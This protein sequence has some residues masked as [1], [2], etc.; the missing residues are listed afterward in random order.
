MKLL[1]FCP[2]YPPHIGGLESHADEFNK[3]L[4]QKEVDIT[5]FA[6]KLPLEAPERE[7]RH[8]GVKIIRFPAF[9]II[10]NYPLPCFWQ[11]KF[12][13]LFFGLFKQKFDIVISRTR[14]FNTSLLALIYAKIKKVHWIHIEHGSDFVSLDNR[15]FSNI[16]K[17]HDYTF[18]KLILK[19]SDKNIANS[20][21]SADFCQKLFPQKYCEV[22]Y[23]GVEIE[24]ILEIKPDITLKNNYPNDIIITFIGRLIDGKGVADLLRAIAQINIPH[25]KCFI[26]GDGPQKNNL[27]KLAKNLNISDKIIFFGYKKHR[28]AIGILKIS[29]IFINPSYNEGLP[30]SVI[31]AAICQKAIIATR[32]GG[33]SEIFTDEKSGFL[34]EPKNITILVEKLNLLINNP[35]LRTNFGASAYEEIKNKFDWEKSIEKYLALLS[36]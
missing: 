10:S 8:N 1:I 32:V 31:E 29:D 14:F 34:I 36:K 19:L 17:L 2:Y 28:E 12:W 22:I 13:K 27:E 15:L 20:I 16:A 23:R 21:A 35:E 24:K 25:I 3:Y 11:L 33:T 30:S 26:I 5:V 6:P 9:E 4:S 7:I 18:G